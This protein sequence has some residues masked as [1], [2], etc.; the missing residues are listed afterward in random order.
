MKKAILM[1]L[2]KSDSKLNDVIIRDQ[3]RQRDGELEYS[4]DVFLEH[5]LQTA[6][7]IDGAIGQ[8][9]RATSS[10]VHEWYG[11]H[12]ENF[13]DMDHTGPD[14]GCDETNYQQG[15]QEHDGELMFNLTG[16]QEFGP[17]V[18]KATWSSHS[19]DDQR[20]WNAVSPHGRKKIASF[21]SK[22]NKIIEKGRMQF[23]PPRVPKNATV[24]TLERER[25]STCDLVPDE[26]DE[27]EQSVYDED[28]G[29]ILNKAHQEEP[30]KRFLHK[31]LGKKTEK[32]P[33]KKGIDRNIKCTRIVYRVTNNDIPEKGG[34]VDRGANGGLAGRD[35][36]VIPTTDRWVDI[37]GINDIRIEDYSHWYCR[38]SC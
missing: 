6:D 29:M 15:I 1:N 22:K 36:R 11:S 38:W 28:V 23:K 14:F 9:R 17:T 37:T 24:V 19:K 27:E 3:Q 25:E 26:V 32:P 20:A 34:L 10:N 33:T 21:F 31:L 5:L 13:L 12:D 2:V 8:G 7:I 16:R 18:D 35:L 4:Y 30:T